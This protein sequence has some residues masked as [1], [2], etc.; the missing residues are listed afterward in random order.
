M[1]FDVTLTHSCL[2]MVEYHRQLATCYTVMKLSN[3]MLQFSSEDNTRK[4]CSLVVYNPSESYFKGH[5]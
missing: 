5:R 3:A 1:S 4:M 2:A